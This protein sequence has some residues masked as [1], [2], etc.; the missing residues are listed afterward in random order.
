MTENNITER[1][2]IRREGR[3]EDQNRGK[4]KFVVGRLRKTQNKRDVYRYIDKPQKQRWISANIYCT[5]CIQ[6]LTGD[7][8]S[9]R[10]NS[11]TRG[12]EATKIVE[13]Q[14]PPLLNEIW[15]ELSHFCMAFNTNEVVCVY[16]L[17]CSCY[18]H[19][20]VDRQTY[21]LIGRKII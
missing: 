8:V 20:N 10:F 4:E 13:Y 16:M 12:L 21:R 1:N 19:M 6:S 7:S 15:S 5:I 11:G 9:P 18:N 17:D 14:N 3:K 2:Q